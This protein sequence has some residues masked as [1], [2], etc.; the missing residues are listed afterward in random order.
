MTTAAS[1]TIPVVSF[2]HLE[3]PFRSGS[4]RDYYAIVATKDLPK[5]DAWRRINVR[6]PKLRGYVPEQIRD[7]FRSQ[8]EMFVFMNRGI[9][10]STDSVAFDNR[11]NHL[12]ITMT[13]PEVHGLLD[14]GHT[15]NII[16]E[17]TPTLEGVQ[18]VKLELL[19]GCTKEDIAQLVDARNTSN[20]VR[21][22]SLMNLA[23]E[24][25]QLK[26]HLKDAPY[27][28]LIA[29][30]EYELG[31]DGS[32]KPI[33][34][35]E[36]IGILTAFDRDN[37]TDTAHPINSYRSKAACLKHFS[38][39]RPSYRKIYPLAQEILR[40]FDHIQ[41]KLP[42][43]YNEVRGKSGGVTG[44]RFG[45]LTG[46]DV[47]KPESAGTTLYYLGGRM[48]YTVPAGFVY[49]IL[50]AFRA[51]L[52]E[53]RGRYVW[54]KGLNPVDLLNGD[55]GSKLAETIG[56]FA[57]EAQNPSKTGKSLLVWQACYQLAQLA[58][59]RAATAG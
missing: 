41:K 49:P 13:D 18:Y 47:H 7:S 12:T 16:F 45:K 28:D 52:E 53:K 38:E 35:R 55:L 25:D 50:G 17:E 30:K 11:K 2:R 5:L 26:Q 46:V 4:I 32:P 23:G 44:G 39:H 40:L 31:P 6:D 54:G 56:N 20:Q 59:L 37:F 48:G 27:F 15:N 29:F 9:V 36:I 1:F 58:Y 19:E 14:G 10:L 51:I 22:E 24:F 3:T 57:L 8:P 33:D 43:L 42:E 21:D 34:I